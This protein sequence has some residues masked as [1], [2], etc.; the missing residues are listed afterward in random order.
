MSRSS[1]KS[2]P[3]LDA[4]ASEAIER[5]VGILSRC[6]YSPRA[7]TRAFS[8]AC[9]RVADSVVRAAGRSTRE[10]S[11][12]S[13]ILTV[14][15]SDP[16]YLDHDGRPIRLAVHGPAPSLEALV[17]R[18]DPRL[19]IE[20]VLQYLRRNHALK[21][22]GT[23]YAPKGRAL[24]LR[25]TRGPDHF[26]NMR[27]LLAMLRTLEHNTRPKRRVA[28]W[29]E[30]FAENPAFPVSARANFD[31]RVFKHGMK[32]LRTMDAD[33]HRQELKRKPGEP[34]VRVGVGVYRF[35]EEIPQARE[36]PG[37]SRTPR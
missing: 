28:G 30:R 6:G 10:L 8:E 31:A 19:D 2:V 29:F 20:E 34:V 1:A 26:R 35:E 5:F 36:P 14:W 37:R 23:R 32:L 11:D 3:A 16:L 33:M 24:V 12:A 22:I 7:M 18:I 15:F 4:S 21:K 27:G 17:A 13:H 25:N 9:A